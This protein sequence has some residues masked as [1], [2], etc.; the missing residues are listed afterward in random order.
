MKISF[1]RDLGLR[2]LTYYLLFVAPVI[3]ASIA[4]DQVA[5]R[6]LDA[7][8]READLALARAIAQETN[9]NLEYSLQAVENLSRY[10][11]VVDADPQGMHELF[12]NL[13][14]A[15]PDV[16]LVYRLD[17]HGKMLFHYPLGP[18]T[19]VGEDFSFRDYFKRAQSSAHPLLSQGRISPTTLQPV[20]TAV[21]PIRDMDDNFLGLVATNMKLQSLSTSLASIAGEYPNEEAFDVAIV[22]AAG[23][24]IAHPDPKQIL[25]ELNNSLPDITSAVLT[26]QSGSVI[27]DDTLGVEMLYSY[28]PIL[29]AGWGVIVSRDTSAAFA[30]LDATHRG[31]LIIIS[32]FLIV[33]VFFWLVLSRQVLGPVERLAELSQSIGVENKASDIEREDLIKLSNR[34]DQIGNLIRSLIRMEEAINARL[35][36]LSTLLETSASVVSSL[37]RQTVLDRILEQVERLLD[38]KMCAIVALDEKHG[39]FRAQ[40]SRGLSKRYTEH[41][42]IFPTEPL[43]VTVRAIRSGEP[44]QIS[45]TEQDASFAPMRPRARSEGYRSILAV[46]LKTQHAPPSA[47]LVY[48]PDA[49]KYTPQEISLLTNFANH[50]AMAIEN[51]A[52]YARSDMRLREQTRTLEALIQSLQD[53]LIL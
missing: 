28:V 44:I 7:D 23:R 17:S 27:Q 12:Q 10:P 53:G 29:S 3:I 13:M 15:R 48:R 1:R 40:A 11:E 26:G 38:I 50:A 30:T 16:N 46:P 4:F 19:T 22:D 45:D 47:L 43:S 18:G 36:E 39:L 34:R 6:R 8:V 9:T 49:H 33:G 5:T 25:L 35:I 21:M 52:L 31:V 24:V 51:A 41:I 20:T 32:V 42:A 2:L 37:D 14:T